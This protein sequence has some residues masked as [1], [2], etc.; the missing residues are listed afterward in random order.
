[1]S[2]TQL[3]DSP[4]VRVLQEKHNDEMERDISES[5][6]STLGTAMHH[7]FEETAEKQGDDVVSEERLFVD[8]E[9]SH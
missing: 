4:R 1:M 5:I 3:I 6:W 7:L 9:G 8:I 2:V